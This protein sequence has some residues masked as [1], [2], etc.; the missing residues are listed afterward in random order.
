MKGE[1]FLPFRRNDVVT[2][3]A[4]E[5]NG[6]DREQFVAFARMLASLLHHRFHETIE[7]L[8]DAYHPFHP[9]ADT[10]PLRTL[11]AAEREAARARVETELTALAR[12]ANFVPMSL[13][14]VE[15]AMAGHSLLKLR[16]EIDTRAVDSLLLFRRGES[17]EAGTETR[18][19]VWRRPVSYVK[20][21]RVLVYAKFKEPDQFTAKEAKKLP[22]RPGS[23]IVKLFQNVPR[24]DLEMIFPN[25]R[26]RMR[27]IDKLLIGVPAVVSGAVVVVQKLFAVIGPI[28][29]LI[30]FWLG[31]TE[32]VEEID[33]AKL[34]GIGIALS[35][36]GAYAWRQINNFKNRK[37]RFMKALSENLYYRNLDNDAGVF[38]HLV[39]AAEEAEVIEAV[40][41]YHFLRAA[42]TPL[43][44][45]ELDH[46]VES[47]FRQRWEHDFDFEVDD[48]LRKLRE[49]GLV[50]TTPDGRYQPI[51]I[52]HALSRLDQLWDDAFNYAEPATVRLPTAIPVI[53]A[54]T[55]VST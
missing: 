12:A 3:C 39:D 4:E 9:E 16:L 51:P 18:F 34:V 36:V 5:L 14:E 42:G 11:D 38:H 21:S 41:A 50:T 19:W 22:F 15:E 24:E 31:L 32:T 2:M 35:T 13:A 49:L 37:I 52:D 20:Y 7:R 8:K 27:L 47:W 10:R 17:V 55:R 46:R 43:T 40:L 25:V 33:S 23:I 53:P 44:A 45:A 30:G 54:P 26:I 6:S 48:G 28:L 1:H 29:L